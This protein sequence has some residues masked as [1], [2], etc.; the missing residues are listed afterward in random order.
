MKERPI[1]YST[2]M[3]I[4]RNAGLKTQTRRT[5]G[6]DKVNENPSNWE[7]L[8]LSIDPVKP[9]MQATFE[10]ILDSEKRLIINCPYG[11]PRDHL[12][13]REAWQHSNYPH[14]PLQ[15]GCDIFYRADY[16]D[17][18]HGMD[19]E[20]SPEGKYRNW[21]PSIHMPRQASRGLDLIENIRLERLLGITMPECEEEG[22]A[23][24]HSS[25]PGYPY[26]EFKTLEIKAAQR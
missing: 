9:L 22:A 4:A 20:K 3:V 15:E 25:I 13:V 2:D 26:I 19:G 12:W 17:D 1:L 7:L 24:G 6:L 5:R 11:K 10:N 21:N 18:P 16:A 23:G 14:G 8:K